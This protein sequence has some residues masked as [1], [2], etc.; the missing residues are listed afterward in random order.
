[1]AESGKLRA[2]HDTNA[3]LHLHDEVYALARV[4]V[5]VDDVVCRGG[6]GL[7]GSG[8]RVTQMS[9]KLTSEEYVAL[10]E[11]VKRLVQLRVVRE[12]MRR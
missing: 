12:K 4:S 3:A 9:G 2:A 1:M 6:Q 8:R 10:H 7:R 11:L 5:S